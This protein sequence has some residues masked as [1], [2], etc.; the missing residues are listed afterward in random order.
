MQAVA[1]RSSYT[2]GIYLSLSI[3]TIKMSTRP[4][5][6]IEVGES[7]PASPPRQRPR[8]NEDGQV[9]DLEDEDRRLVDWSVQEVM[10][11]FEESQ[12]ET[13]MDSPDVVTPRDGPADPQNPYYGPV[14]VGHTS[15]LYDPSAVTSRAVPRRL[16]PDDLPPDGEG[17]FLGENLR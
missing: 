8:L 5:E 3:E 6:V 14:R 2:V 16:F 9:Q 1:F 17:P 15:P 12:D 4:H 13:V 11:Y 10:Q 7:P